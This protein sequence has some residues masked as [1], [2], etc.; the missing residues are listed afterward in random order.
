MGEGTNT[1]VDHTEYDFR[2]FA[3]YWSGSQ[4]DFTTYSQIIFTSTFQGVPINQ[5][6]W[7][8]DTL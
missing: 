2:L 1:A 4:K 6:G 7:W 3:Y 8:I 5:K